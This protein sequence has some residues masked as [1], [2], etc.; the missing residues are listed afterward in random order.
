MDEHLEELNKIGCKTVGRIDDIV[1]VISDR[2]RG[3]V[4]EVM[5]AALNFIEDW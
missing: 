3:N 5:Q 1:I 4:S 2:L